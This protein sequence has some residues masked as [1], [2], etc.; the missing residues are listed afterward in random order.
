M[1][2]REIV[3]RRIVFVDDESRII[4]GLRRMLHKMGRDWEM[5]FA[6]NGPEALRLLAGETFDVIVTDMRMPGMDGAGLLAEVQRGYPHMVRIILSG[7]SSDE[8]IIQAT[9]LA[10]QFLMKPCEP[11]LL[12]R[13]IN[14]ACALRDLL[15]NEILERIVSQTDS[16]PSLPDL[17]CRLMEEM[18]T[19][20]GSIQRVGEIIETDLSMSAKVIQLVSSAF[21]GLPRRI[22]RP[23]E[24]VMLLG[25]DTV[26]A[27]ALTLGLFSKF[28]E[29]TL[30]FIPVKRIYEHSMKT[31]LLAREIAGAEGADTGMAAD[32][33]MT[34]LLH[35]VGKLLLGHNIPDIYQRVF[36]R[37]SREEIPFFEAERAE[38]GATHG[39]V[40]AYLLGLWGLPDAVVEGVA[41]HHNLGGSLAKG[42]E[43]LIAVHVASAMENA[44]C[45]SK[46]DAAFVE[47]VDME[48]LDR[49]GLKTRLPAWIEACHEVEDL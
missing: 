14:R 49:L 31:G 2:E 44:A 1:T 26:K 6:Q 21:F 4:Q 24:A 20:E 30:S 25:L 46:G 19:S 17:Y 23:S 47:G 27:L 29:S 35:D 11:A 7:L 5:K 8:M 43:P 28:E 38:L 40:G 13:T 15:N 3:K 22:S 10:H 18:R 48:G 16:L 33:F 41:F 34:G 39:E 32:A 36:E 12:I 45:P 42:F 37:S 9:G